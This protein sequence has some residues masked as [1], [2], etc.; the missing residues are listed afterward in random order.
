MNARAARCDFLLEHRRAIDL[1]A[2]R[3]VLIAS[4]L[5][6][7]F[8]IVDVGGRAVPADDAALFVAQGTVPDEEPSILSIVPSGALL[9]LE[10][11]AA[12]QRAGTLLLESFHV[13]LVKDAPTEIRTARFVC[14]KARV[15]E[16]EFIDVQRLAVRCEDRDHLRNHVDHGPEFRLGFPHRSECVRQRRLSAMALNREECD[17]ARLL[18]DFDLV[19]T[20]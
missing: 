6:R 4:P 3:D 20:N 15:F 1:F 18:D 12:R 2:Q 19:R 11:A 10:R 8:T 14:R 5:F 13:F 17:V 7:A 16:S 9:V